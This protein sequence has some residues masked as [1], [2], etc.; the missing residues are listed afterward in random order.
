M[1]EKVIVSS[2][3]LFVEKLVIVGRKKNYIVSF[4]KGLNIIYG[5][6]D[7]GKSSILNI[8]NYC[9]GGSE[10][11]MY[12]ELEM[13]GLYCLLQVSLNGTQFTIKRDLFDTSAFV[14]VFNSD[15]ANIDTIFPREYGP[16]YKKSGQDGYFSDFMLQALNLPIIKVR[17]APT[18]DDSSQVRLSFR[19]IFKY[20]YLDQ[21][22]VGSKNLLDNKNFSQY[23]KVKQ[24]FKFIHKLL[25]TQIADLEEDIGNKTALKKE[26]EES[27]KNISSFFRETQLGT[28]ESLNEELEIIADKM[29]KV[30]SD[31]KTI[32]SNMTSDTM[33]FDEIRQTIQQFQDKINQKS[34]EKRNKE[35]QLEQKLRLKKNYQLDKEKLESSL[36]ITKRLPRSESINVDCPIC[37][38]GMSFD[39]L[40]TKLGANSTNTIE[41]EIRHINSHI[42]SI[43]S[44]IEDER[45]QIT[46]IDNQIRL[47]VENLNKYKDFLDIETNKFISPYVQQRDIVMSSKASLIEEKKKIEHFKKLRKQLNE[48]FNEGEVLSTQIL[49]LKGQ[50]ENLKLTTPSINAVLQDITDHLDEFLKFIPI[51]N[52]SDISVSEKTFLPVVRNRDYVKLTSGGLRTLVSIGFLMSILKNSI[53][54]DT[55]YPRFLMIDTVGKYIG[56]TATRIKL[57]ETPVN[58]NNLVNQYIQQQNE[59]TDVAEDLIENITD[60]HKY[61]NL[62]EF[63]IGFNKKYNHQMQII[64]VDNDLPADVEDELQ[65]FVVKHFKVD[66]SN[67]CEIGLI[68]DA[69]FEHQLKLQK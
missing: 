21:D 60:P 65:Q 16:N 10:I 69:Q 48:L 18:K 29:D 20:C 33:Q 68:D 37:E 6:S 66:G 7:T 9:L 47:L 8:I 67:E 63:F 14:E 57:S 2:P 44:F 23:N 17:Q 12:S 24:T 39:F 31:I 32:T 61:K 36:N 5:D 49:S 62:Y 45:Q 22:D 34:I 55:Y 52:P 15:I 58:Q 11:D 38:R 30:Q 59:D 19:D 43:E 42:K 50:L 25:D 13:N 41:V 46:T 3:S 35:T 64:I 54:K 53:L 51:R 1:G 26:K 40:Q 4:T 56:K 28:L 27:Y